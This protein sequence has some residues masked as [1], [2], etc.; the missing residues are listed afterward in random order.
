M[1]NTASQY[2]APIK[3]QT[4]SGVV[5]ITTVSHW[6]FAA[7]DA[8]V[9][10]GCSECSYDVASDEIDYNYFRYYDPSTGRYT[11]SD[12]IGLDGGINTY[13]Y[14]ENNPLI[15]IDPYG[16]DW[17]Y[18]QSTGQTTQVV[19]GQTVA[20]QGGTGYAGHGAGVNNSAAQN[21]PNVGPIPQGTYTI[22]AQQN[23]VTNSGT[24]LVQ[25][26]RL[27]PDS[28]NTMFG[29]AGF[30]I[31]GDNARGNQSASEGCPILN[32]AV[33]NQMSNSGDNILRVVP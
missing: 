13:A 4:A 26:M 15:R 24:R 18:S 32:R 25:S 33:R 31:H 27:T 9:H 21:Q 5:K 1:Q 3:P 7:N 22:E 11:Q 30:L 29:R 19:N 28:N 23:N 14:V 17:V 12:P 2:L 20:G 8:R 6:A 16:L 10:R